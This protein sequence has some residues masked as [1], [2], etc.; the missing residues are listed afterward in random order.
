MNL[1]ICSMGKFCIYKH[2]RIDDFCYEHAC[3]DKCGCNEEDLKKKIH[4]PV[5]KDGEKC[6]K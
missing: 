4:I 3:L 1:G 5:C 2:P 6:E